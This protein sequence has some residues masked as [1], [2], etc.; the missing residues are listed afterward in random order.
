MTFS[1]LRLRLYRYWWV[2]LAFLVL[3]VVVFLPRVRVNTYVASISFGLH[4]NNLELGRAGENGD[5][6]IGYTDSL[7]D[8]SIYLTNRFTALEI[9]DII[10]REM[11]AP[12]F[13]AE[14]DAFYA[15]VNQGAGFVNLTLQAQSEKE[16]RRFLT[17]AKVAYEQLVTEW[18]QVRLDEFQADPQS[19]FQET[20][21]IQSPTLQVQAVPV[22]AG[23]LLGVFTILVLPLP[24][25][26]TK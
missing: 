19:E 10:A 20:V 6:I 2:L 5:E 8:F 24:A 13:Y 17:G 3:S 18:N 21:V 23:F 15:V 11:D 14:Q 7:T 9:Q 22:V 4:Y 12:V 26:S 16:A 25:K 1:T